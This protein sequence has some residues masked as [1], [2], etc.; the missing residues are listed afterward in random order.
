MTMRRDMRLVSCVVAAAAISCGGNKP[1]P[2][3][4]TGAP[5]QQQQ[6]Q[7]V[8]TVVSIVCMVHKTPPQL[9][10]TANGE[11]PTGGW[12]GPA[13]NRRTYVAAPA[14]S[15]WE[16]DFVATPPTGMA[17]QMITPITAEDMWAHFPAQSIVGVRVYGAGSGVKEIRLTNC[18]TQ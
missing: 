17:T 4:D 11:V 15:I 2:G 12:T 18:A 6:Q 13:L 10:V 3:V 1:E 16:Y 7:T 5:S 14:D 8:P 9:H